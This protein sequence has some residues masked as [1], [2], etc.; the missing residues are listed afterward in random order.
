MNHEYRPMKNSRDSD[1]KKNFSESMKL[2]NAQRGFIVLGELKKSSTD[3]AVCKLPLVCC[4]SFVV[5]SSNVYVF[6]EQPAMLNSSGHQ[7][8]NSLMFSNFLKGFFEEP[9]AINP[10]QIESYQI[11]SF[12]NCIPLILY[13]SQIEPSQILS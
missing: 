13:P 1:S 3:A 8:D 5:K 4:V 6:G 9:P 12:S 2:D 10:A 7:V 11:V